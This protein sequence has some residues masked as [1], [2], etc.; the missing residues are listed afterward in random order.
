MKISFV[1]WSLERT[2]GVRVIFEVANRL[3][4]RKHKVN[5]V[6]LGGN[7]DWFPLKVNAHTASVL[8]WQYKMSH[9][10]WRSGIQLLNILSLAREIEDSDV[11]LAT[12]YPT[13][14]SVCIGGSGT[15]FYYIQHYETIMYMDANT[16]FG[17][18]T[19]N[20]MVP[21]ADGT[22]RLRLNWLVNSSWANN[23]LKKKFG[24]DGLLVYPAIDHE[25][26]FPRK[27]DRTDEK[28]R[29]V[30]LGKTSPA[31]GLNDGLEAVKLVYKQMS[32]IELIL[33]GSEPDVHI[34]VPGRYLFK[35]S[36]DELAELYSSADVVICPSWFE[37]FPLPPLE[38]MGCG[39]PV[40]TTR[41]GTEDYAFDDQNCLV[42]PAKQPKLLSNA[43]LK[44]L[45]SNDL[46]T[47]LKNEG[48]KTAQ[49]F[50]WERTATTI[51]QAFKSATV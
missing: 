22:Y 47:R 1:L 11:T 30:C 33:Y 48:L 29:I 41:Y 7:V 34:P 42:V 23:L 14:Y 6:A 26:F 40:V 27:I 32:N 31:K 36:D 18:I 24:R 25:K 20:L 10:G 8:P 3:S 15:L 44:I 13:A 12:F 28:K 9:A 50:T 17:K 51:E 39:A 49:Q 43:I 21:I 45:S 38:A 4:A 5:I 37:S 19:N 2:G 46:A 35:P 16:L